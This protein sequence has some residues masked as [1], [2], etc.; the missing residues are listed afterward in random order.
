[1]NTL[2]LVLE[3]LENQKKIDYKY[4]FQIPGLWL[5]NFNDKI[6]RINPFDFFIDRINR[7]IQISSENNKQ[8]EIVYNLFVRYV[9][10]YD[11]LS[12]G[13]L[14]EQPNDAFRQTGTFLK[15][16][17]LLPYLKNLDVG[18][19]YLLP[20][21]SIGKYGKKG[22]L[23]SP[24][25]INNPYKLDESLSEPL[26]DLSIE[27]QFTALV[28]AAHMLGMKVILEFVFRTASIDSELAL[29]HP[30]WFYWIYE[31]N[32]VFKPPKFSDETLHIIKE[33]IEK[34]DFNSLP[35][36]TDD[37]KN[38]FANIP[39][40]VFYDKNRKIIGEDVKGNRLTIPSAFA[41]WPPDDNQPL[42]TDV[43]YLKLYAHP[44]FNY[45]AYNTI[46]MYDSELMQEKY[47]NKSLWEHIRKIVPSYIEK[48]NIDGVMID[49]G[50][51]LPEKL[52]KSIIADS[53]KIKRDFIF[54]EENFNVN[55]KSK[56]EGYDAVVGYVP[57]D[58]HICWKMK[59]IIK[60]FELKNYPITFFLTPENHNTK[61]AAARQG[62]ICFSKMIWTIFSFLPAI[63]FIHN[64]FEIG[65]TSPINTGLGFSDDEIAEFPP[66]KLSL[67]SALSMNW[68]NSTDLVNYI[69]KLNKQIDDLKN[70]LKISNFQN[71]KLLETPENILAFVTE[72]CILC[73]ANYSLKEESLNL[74]VFGFKSDVLELNIENDTKINLNIDEEIKLNSFEIRIFLLKTL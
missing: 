62:G 17:A 50:H 21:T 59:Q 69:I 2:K 42:W 27:I 58:S 68:D 9:T 53:R 73:I 60:N 54:W 70:Q 3:K 66:E 63:K 64:G 51:A 1:M 32:D 7:I 8:S 72:N 33:K 45:I 20:I 67:F 14:L 13:N 44:N 4:N 41:D 39:I 12:S 48:Y 10:A 34:S 11:H 37:Y 47:E 55:E 30:E 52:M 49:M 71:I 26:L 35:S 22:N 43:T 31:Q 28:E 6:I 36:P 16:I 23:G 40:K 38:T 15:T 61:R 46:R 18:I 5:E 56:L 19:L 25:A 24:Y 74:S 29:K 57:F 65:E